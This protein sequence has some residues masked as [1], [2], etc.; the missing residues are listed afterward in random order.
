MK[1]SCV[2]CV[3]V[4]LQGGRRSGEDAI[5]IRRFRRDFLRKKKSHMVT[6]GP[7]S[8]SLGK[9]GDKGVREPNQKS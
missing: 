9:K 2:F 7:V 1:N 3:R 6:Q 4:L 5:L 8:R